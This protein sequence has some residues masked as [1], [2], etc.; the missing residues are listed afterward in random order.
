MMVPIV[1]LLIQ[2]N[3]WFGHRALKPSESAVIAVKLSDKAS[4]VLSRVTIEADG[5]LAI[6]TPPLRI[7]ETGTVNWRIRGVEQGEHNL[8]IT[9]SDHTFQKEVIVEAGRLNR[10]S[11]R[12]VASILRSLLNPGEN[13]I[14]GNP[15][16]KEIEVY[17]PSQSIEFFGWKFHWLAIFFVLSVAI[18]FG[19]RRV[20]NVEI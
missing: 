15:Y 17:Y 10:V 11:T 8:I 14:A 1:I 9:A 6:E 16:V 13:P 19:F 20:F 3:G 5:G 2:L 12:V 18:G 7:P 4:A